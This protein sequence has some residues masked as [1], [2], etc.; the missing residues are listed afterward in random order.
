MPRNGEIKKTIYMNK[1]KLYMLLLMAMTLVCGCSDE[2]EITEERLV[3]EPYDAKIDGVC[4]Q[5]DS[6]AQTAVV[7]AGDMF[8]ADDVVIPATVEH[9]GVAYRM[10]GIA[11]KAFANCEQLRSLVIPEGVRTIPARMCAWCYDL[12]TVTLPSSITSIGDEAFSNCT[13]LTA[14]SIP[15]GVE[16]IGESAFFCCTSLTSVVVPN[17]VSTIRWRAFTG[18]ANL[19]SVSLPEKLT[20]IPSECFAHC[21]RLSS[22]SIPEG[23]VYISNHSFSH[24]ISLT[25]LMLPESLKSMD[26]GVFENCTGLTSITIPEGVEQLG[27]LLFCECTHLTSVEWH[28]QT[29]PEGTFKNCTALVE[30][31]VPEGVTHIQANA[32]DGCSNLST[33]TLPSTLGTIAPGAFKD[34]RSLKDVYCLSAQVPSLPYSIES[35]SDLIFE[36]IDLSTATLHVPA[37]ALEVYRITPP[38]STFGK[39]TGDGSL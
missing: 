14:V 33:L 38:W 19:V 31:R 20:R 25:Q 3:H 21:S 7:T 10:T 5:L 2:T 27:A 13:S 36:N 18:C 29:V 16:E 37:S 17:S 8:Y 24:C 12:E 1:V 28:P 32:F 6:D 39:L 9:Q 30:V 35:T 15:D 23:V 34:C 26:R 11:E 4:Y 22:V